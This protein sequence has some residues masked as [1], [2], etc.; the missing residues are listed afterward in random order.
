MTSQLSHKLSELPICVPAPAK[1]NLALHVVGRNKYQYHLLDSLVTFT[2]YGDQILVEHC[3]RLCLIIKG[4]ESQHLSADGNNLVLRAAESLRETAN[5]PDLTASITLEKNLPVAS[6]IGGGSADAAAT[7]NALNVLWELNLSKDQLCE[8]GLT[9]G[10]DIP[11]CIVGKPARI[12]GIGERIQPINMPSQPIVLCNS[13]VSVSTPEV[14]SKLHQKKNA[15]LPLSCKNLDWPE[16]LNKMR[17]DLTKPA[18]G[19]APSICTTIEMLENS[20]GCQIARMS[21]SGATCYG[22]FT[23]SAEA[24][25]AANM[26]RDR[27]PKWWVISTK[28]IASRRSPSGT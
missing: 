21:G 24:V 22:L 14:F 2:E 8:I 4:P 16:C 5:N 13:G 15:A 19:V 23:S 12:R 11:M 17:N 6:G 10:A 9:L 25:L 7:L 20:R 18:I 1:I 3:D 26:I 28:T 27:Y